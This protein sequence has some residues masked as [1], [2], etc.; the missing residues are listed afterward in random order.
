M[1]N[2]DLEPL[3]QALQ[4]EHAPFLAH[5]RPPD[6]TH[7]TFPAPLRAFTL[8]ETVG[9]MAVIAILAAVIVP[10]VIKRVDLAAYSAE[11]ANLG[12][13]TNALTQQ[14]LLNKN[15][16]SQATWSSAVANWLSLPLSS[17]TNNARRN[18]RA[19]LIDTGGWLTAAGY[20]QT[21]NGTTAATNSARVMFVSSVGSALPASLLSSTPISTTDF[22]VIWNTSAGQ[23]P[24]NSFS[25]T[26]AKGADLL[27]QRMNLQPLFYQLIL[28]NLDANPNLACFTADANSSPIP[29]TNMFM[30]YY[31]DGTVL[32]LCS[33]NTTPPTLQLR[34][35]LKRNT[36][37]V[38]DSGQWGGQI[39]DGRPLPIG[40]TNQP[41]LNAATFA[42]EALDFFNS[43]LNPST[44]NHQFGS[45]GMVLNALGGF[46]LDYATWAS[47]DFTTRGSTTEKKA[48]KDAIASLLSSDL[49][50]IQNYGGSGDPGLLVLPGDTKK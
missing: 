16:P 3:S 13:F 11:Q 12:N 45:Q 15:I 42:N 28:N 8:L 19:Y 38:Y 35:V 40:S 6:A 1:S 23:V 9:V 17:I 27:I 20:T 2:A 10:V 47:M 30:S 31:F 37:F 5:T 18:A 43:N 48:K 4:L 26:G 29:V 25:W 36:S 46:M 21:T 44:T 14:I 39:F 33:S 49:K 7:V 41:P 24:T 32:G 50:N 34:C 22:N